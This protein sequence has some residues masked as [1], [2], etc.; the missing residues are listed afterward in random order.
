[1]VL[2]IPLMAI[3]PMIDRI[4]GGV[5]KPAHCRQPLTNTELCHAQRII[6]DVLEELKYT[7]QNNGQIV[8]ELELT[9]VQIVSNPNYILFANP[10]DEVIVLCFE[11][12]LSDVPSNR[13]YHIPEMSLCIPMGELI[14]HL[15]NVTIKNMS[16]ED[17]T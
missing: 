1:M 13:S 4:L 9:I 14:D 10:N 15:T 6:D 8:I 12:S 3:N 16:D 5:R 7:W 17:K 2:D 11:V